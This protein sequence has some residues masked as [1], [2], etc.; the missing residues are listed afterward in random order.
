MV[1]ITDFTIDLDSYEIETLIVQEYDSYNYSMDKKTL[2]KKQFLQALMYD[3]I[4]E[5]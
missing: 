1:D 4:R 5:D 2:R 3:D